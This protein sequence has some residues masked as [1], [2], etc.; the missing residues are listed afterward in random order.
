MYLNPGI[1]SY[2]RFL[3]GEG[4]ALFNSQ[5]NL[6]SPFVIPVSSA[7]EV[8]QFLFNNVTF[9]VLPSNDFSGAG[10]PTDK[11]KWKCIFSNYASSPGCLLARVA[12]LNIKF[13]LHKSTSLCHTKVSQSHFF[14]RVKDSQDSDQ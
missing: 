8:F 5:T 12:T 2:H 10:L 1:C 9:G 11:L 13:S 7:L 6:T 4:N 3:V 14:N